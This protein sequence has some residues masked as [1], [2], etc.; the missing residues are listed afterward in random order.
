MKPNWPRKGL[1]LHHLPLSSWDTLAAHTVWL[2]IA[3][4]DHPHQ[5]DCRRASVGVLWG[6]KKDRYPRTW[7]VQPWSKG[8]E[9]AFLCWSCSEVHMAPCPSHH[10]RSTEMPGPQ[11]TEE[12]FGK[13]LSPLDWGMEGT[14]RW[15][16]MLD[17]GR[18]HGCENKGWAKNKVAWVKGPESEWEC[19]Q[20][21]NSELAG[22]L[23]KVRPS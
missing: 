15:D 9:G 7:H 6:I 22:F 12:S 20:R 19:G 5:S 1:A 14:E 23:C 17:P 21:L 16:N 4:T 11:H 8:H 18:Q 3:K 2:L 10:D 13:P